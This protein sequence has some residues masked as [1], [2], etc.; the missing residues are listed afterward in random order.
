MEE[1]PAGKIGL[2]PD[3]RIRCGISDGQAAAND[4]TNHE[5]DRP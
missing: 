3:T 4:G 5:G 1:P 2:H